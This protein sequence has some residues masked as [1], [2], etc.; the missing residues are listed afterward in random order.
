[1]DDILLV[2][3]RQKTNIEQTL[4]EFNNMQPT[5]KFTIEKEQK[6]KINY[7][8]I[9]I[10]QKKRKVWNSQYTENQHKQTS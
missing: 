1:V 4:E 5:I 9:T 6:V 10:Q 8:D 2:Y 3:D 7:L